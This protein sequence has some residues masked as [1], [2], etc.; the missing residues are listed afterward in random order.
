MALR[1]IALLLAHVGMDH[2]LA[3]LESDGENAVVRTWVWCRVMFFGPF[4]SAIV[5]QYSTFVDGRDFLVVCIDAPTP[6]V[7]SLY[8][9]YGILKWS[10]APN[11]PH[12]HSPDHAPHTH[13]EDRHT[14]TDSLRDLRYVEDGEDVWLGEGKMFERL[15]EEREEELRWLRFSSFIVLGNDS[16]TLV[17][18][19]M[20]MTATYFVFTVVMG[21]KLTLSVVFPSMSV[22]LDRITVFLRDTELLDLHVLKQDNQVFSASPSYQHQDVSTI[23]LRDAKISLITGLTGGGKTSLLMALLGEMHCIALH[24]FCAK[25]TP[26]RASW[27]SRF[28]GAS[29][30]RAF[31]TIHYDGVDTANL[32][33][34]DLSAKITNLPQV[35]QLLSTRPF[36]EYDDAVLNSALHPCNTAVGTEGT[37]GKHSSEGT[38]QTL[39]RSSASGTSPVSRKG[40]GKD[41]KAKKAKYSNLVGNNND[42]VATEL[43]NIVEGCDS[44]LLGLHS[45]FQC[46]HPTPACRM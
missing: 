33:L 8:F 25:C 45:P 17:I 29:L 2:L 15:D 18:P 27:R 19:V 42:L 14:R 3:Y 46:R 43:E 31:S 11:L 39:L 23:G 12:S 21:G 38:E 22:S 7:I 41:K 37:R 24:T 35:P 36:G 1:A 6:V 26:A 32:N 44:L 9:L 4:A 13:A 34:N 10:N 20:Q 16:V 28:S 5:T 30:A 40:K